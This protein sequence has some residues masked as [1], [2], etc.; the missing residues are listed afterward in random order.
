MMEHYYR[1]TW[2]MDGLAILSKNYHNIPKVGENVILDDKLYQVKEI[3]HVLD[4]IHEYQRSD[5]HFVNIFI[6][7]VNNNVLQR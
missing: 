3:T 4:K 5:I 2:Y 1:V 6:T 7:K